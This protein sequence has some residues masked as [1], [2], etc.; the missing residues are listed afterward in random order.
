MEALNRYTLLAAIAGLLLLPSSGVLALEQGGGGGMPANG[1]PDNILPS[2]T[3]VVGLGVFY[4]KYGK[5]S[6][7]VNAMGSNGPSHHITIKKPSADAVVKKAFLMAASLDSREIANGDIQLNGV[8]I[9][10]VSSV[11]NLCA[12]CYWEYKPDY[13][14]NVLADVTTIVKPA[15]D[16]AAP[17]DIAFPVVET[18]TD[19]ID[20]E[21]LVVVF[22]QPSLS[23]SRTVALLFGAQP[24]SGGRFEIGLNT[25]LNPTALD[26]RAD[27]GLGISFGYQGG[28]QYSTVKVNGNLLS[29]AAGGQD[30]GGLFDGSL[31]TVGGV[32]DANANPA[33]PNALPNGDP[34]FDDELYSLLPWIKKTDTS[35]TV[36]TVNPSNNDNIF[37]AYF[38]LSTNADINKDTDGDGLLDE[39]E[40][41]GYDHDSDGVVDVNLPGMGAN[42][43]HKDIF[44]E[45]DWMRNA[46]HSHK[47]TLGVMSRVISAFA[48][49]PITNPDGIN[50]ITLHLDAGSLKGGNAVAHDDDLAP[51]WTDFDAIKAVNFK[52]ERA[53]IFHYCLFAHNYDGDGSSG[54]SRGIPASDFIVTLGSW[55]NQVGTAKQQA[56][57]LMHELGHNLGL[58]HGG[59]DHVNYKPNYLSI[60]NYFFQVDWLNFDR[61]ARLDYSRVNTRALDEANL[62]EPASLNGAK[63]TLEA[64]LSHY[65]TQWFDALGRIKGKLVGAQRLVDWNGNGA[66][67]N[68]GVSVDLNGDGAVNTLT[69]GYLDWQNLEFLGGDVGVNGISALSQTKPVPELTYKEYLQMKNNQ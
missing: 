2:A 56:G 37:F 7:S 8:G 11:R 65:G 40:S 47:P 48:N 50:G 67:N 29:S 59:S 3:G 32:G 57:T 46:S 9:N 52:P 58:R 23:K 20:G 36:D 30:D 24:V 16:A 62:S 34:A 28:E 10:W 12:S 38:D 1:L 21:I 13:F 27:M 63:G 26:A 60:M 22:D 6:L 64:D 39:W 42:P 66:G 44:I 69:G 19:T 41:N 53:R 31:I 51:V 35:I 61:R 54:L 49:A 25:P 33:D 55:D 18:N 14:D 45:I 4:R 15:V 17:G 5:L 43:K 68:L